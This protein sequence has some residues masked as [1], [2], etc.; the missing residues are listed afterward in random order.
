[1]FL[2]FLYDMLTYSFA[3]ALDADLIS[4]GERLDCRCSVKGNGGRWGTK[5]LLGLTET[6]PGGLE[7]HGPA[8][9]SRDLG[10]G[11]PQEVTTSS[12]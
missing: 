12:I 10:C 7:S 5:V 2:M 8:L 1:M 3:A 4:R 11:A 6:E 9:F